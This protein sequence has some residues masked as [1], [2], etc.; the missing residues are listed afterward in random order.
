MW[1]VKA[2]IGESDENW[3]ECCVTLLGCVM[4]PCLRE[5][6]AVVSHPDLSVCLLLR[7]NPVQ[8]GRSGHMMTTVDSHVVVDQHHSQASQ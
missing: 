3:R 2:D 4:E 7:N 8:G 5:P 6:V 1:G